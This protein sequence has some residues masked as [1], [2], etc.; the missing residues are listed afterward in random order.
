MLYQTR[1]S[2][3][4]PDSPEYCKTLGTWA[5]IL[6]NLIIVYRLLECTT[7]SMVGKVWEF[8]GF[9]KLGMN[10]SLTRLPSGCLILLESQSLV[11]ASRWLSL[12]SLI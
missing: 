8:S 10:F 9:S 2:L 5:F 11:K 12:Q 1:R 3:L 7:G 6:T 4:V